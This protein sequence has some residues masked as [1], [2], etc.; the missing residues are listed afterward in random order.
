MDIGF[1]HG[2]LPRPFKTVFT[3]DAQGLSSK[4]YSLEEARYLKVFGRWTFQAV[5]Q[6]PDC[7][8]RTALRSRNTKARRRISIHHPKS[9]FQLLGA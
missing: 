6:T 4:V 3:Q 8:S 9:I 5:E 2:V 1:L 7:L